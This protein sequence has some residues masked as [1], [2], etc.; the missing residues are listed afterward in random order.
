MRERSKSASPNISK[1]CPEMNKDLDALARMRPPIQKHPRM[2]SAH[3]FQ[4]YLTIF[5]WLIWM[6][7]VGFF[8]LRTTERP[9]S[10]NLTLSLV[11]AVLTFVD[12]FGLWL[13][14][15]R[16]RAFRA[17]V[18]RERKAP[19]AGPL[20]AM[21]GTA[22]DFRETEKPEE[23][24]PEMSKKGIFRSMEGPPER[25]YRQI[26][27]LGGVAVAA[28]VV[29]LLTGITGWPLFIPGTGTVKGSIAL[30]LAVWIFIEPVPK[31][32]DP[33][34]RKGILTVKTGL[35][36]ALLCFASDHYFPW[37]G[38]AGIAAGGIAIGMG[39]RGAGIYATC[40]SAASFALQWWGFT[41]Q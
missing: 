8:S 2:S 36:L 10:V 22:P 18:A 7:V 34:H 24:G 40:I 20:S 29:I 39:R 27:Y 17:Q 5:G 25:L 19:A 11:I 3:A 31:E 4:V 32:N 35:G 12:L 37:F 38:G 30:A 21:A 23:S 28:A 15:G 41:L 14:I 9:I 33:Q 13:T 6:M 26:V 1:R 16:W